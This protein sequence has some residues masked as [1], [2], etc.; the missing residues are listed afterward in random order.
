MRKDGLEALT[1]LMLASK[2]LIILG[3]PPSYFALSHLRLYQYIGAGLVTS[4]PG[5]LVSG[6]FW[7]YSFSIDGIVVVVSFLISLIF[8]NS[9]SKW[10]L[11][12]EW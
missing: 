1:K 2:V 5:K 9:T 3:I 11:E 7:A 10:L 6:L 8:I 4:L 12:M